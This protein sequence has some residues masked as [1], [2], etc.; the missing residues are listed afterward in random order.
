MGKA[1]DAEWGSWNLYKTQ[2]HL[3]QVNV[4]TPVRCS[5]ILVEKVDPLRPRAL[6]LTSPSEGTLAFRTPAGLRGSLHPPPLLMLSLPF[7]PSGTPDPVPP[8]T[9]LCFSLRSWPALEIPVAATEVPRRHPAPGSARC[10]SVC[11]SPRSRLRDG[12]RAQALQPQ[13]S[14]GCSPQSSSS[15]PHFSAP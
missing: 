10:P 7:V 2:L 14:R 11:G 9:Q 12:W 15:L 4:V 8:R 3:F 1:D 5:S 13:G 6:T